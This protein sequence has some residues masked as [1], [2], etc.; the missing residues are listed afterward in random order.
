M[1]VVFRSR[2]NS[3]PKVSVIPIGFAQQ[4]KAQLV[5]SRQDIFTFDKLEW[6]SLNDSVTTVDNNGLVVGQAISVAGAKTLGLLQNIRRVWSCYSLR[7]SKQES[8]P[9]D[10]FVCKTR[11][12]AYGVSSSRKARPFA[13]NALAINHKLKF[14]QV[15]SF[16]WPDNF[17]P[18]LLL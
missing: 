10:N 3:P 13:V 17:A 16:H 1:K 11:G 7:S 12:E 14:I 8:T 4:P 5:N 2:V 9:L 18:I 6:W 15:D